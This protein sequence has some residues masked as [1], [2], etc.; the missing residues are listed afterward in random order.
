MKH[1]LRYRRQAALE[2]RNRDVDRYKALLK[3][4]PKDKALRRKLKI[5]RADVVNTERNLKND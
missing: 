2:R 5:A 1:N 4:D 3:N